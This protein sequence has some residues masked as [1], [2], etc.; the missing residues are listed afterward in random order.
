MT[1]RYPNRIIAPVTGS[2]LRKLRRR[3]GKTQKEMADLTGV[4]W[5]TV[6]RYERDELAI[7]EPLARLVTLI[8]RTQKDYRK[9]KKS[10]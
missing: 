10:K 1:R 3:L 7:P 8:S 6:A 4:H 9:R 5:N 2:Q